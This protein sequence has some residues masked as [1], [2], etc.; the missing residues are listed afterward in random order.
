MLRLRLTQVATSIATVGTI[1]RLVI[2]AVAP[3]D[4]AQ[5]LLLLFEL[6]LL[7]AVL[8]RGAFHGQSIEQRHTT[9]R[10]TSLTAKESSSRS[11]SSNCPVELPPSTTKMSSD[12]L[13]SS[14][15]LIRE[16]IHHE[17]VI[18]LF[19]KL[20]LRTHEFICSL[21]FSL[22]FR[23]LFD[24]ALQVLHEFLRALAS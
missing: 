22:F 2:V 5:I 20:E 21:G 19:E 24:L 14:H 23:E 18:L 6:K 1:A 9:I 11:C 10:S 8:S 15:A 13:S 17:R 12:S 3:H 4:L 16:L 7:K